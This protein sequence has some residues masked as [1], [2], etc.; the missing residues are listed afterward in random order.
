MMHHFISWYV[1]VILCT[2]QEME[3]SSL[4]NIYTEESLSC[5]MLGSTSLEWKLGEER[6]NIRSNGATCACM[7]TMRK[8]MG[9][10]M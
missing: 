6:K 7:T 2:C 10:F 9:E 5:N 4:L 1:V 3:V 8:S